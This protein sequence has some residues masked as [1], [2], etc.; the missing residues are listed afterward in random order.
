MKK[1]GNEKLDD[2]KFCD[3]TAMIVEV[4]LREVD[5][6]QIKSDQ[7]AASIYPNFLASWMN[8]FEIRECMRKFNREK[9][10]DNILVASQNYS[11]S[12]MDEVQSILVSL[13]LGKLVTVFAWGSYAH[14][15]ACP[16]SD[17]DLL[18]IIDE[19]D[20]SMILEKLY[21]FFDELAE[22]LMNLDRIAGIPI[23]T[24]KEFE[25]KFYTQRDLLLQRQPTVALS[26]LLFSRSM[27]SENN[28]VIAEVYVYLPRHMAV[29]LY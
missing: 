27:T 29:I 12:I 20:E 11:H 5:R 28:V 24:V 13:G 26:A 23:R 17:L 4:F 22:G 10:E 15:L 1:F 14:L 7:S 16:Q 9:T 19:R 18:L 25:K 6:R 2:V 8:G 21:I 3:E